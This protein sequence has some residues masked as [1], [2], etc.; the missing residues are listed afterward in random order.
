MQCSVALWLPWHSSQWTWIFIREVCEC[1]F[2]SKCGKMRFFLRHM[3]QRTCTK[4]QT[5]GALPVMPEY[6]GGFCTVMIWFYQFVIGFLWTLSDETK[7]G[8]KPIRGQFF[9]I[10]FRNWDTESSFP[11]PS[12]AKPT[13]NDF[14]MVIDKFVKVLPSVSQWLASV[15]YDWTWVR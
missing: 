9:Q 10:L 1:V 7:I 3:S 5:S 14:V 6:L 8:P 13:Q 2:S 11:R 12:F 15:D 4:S